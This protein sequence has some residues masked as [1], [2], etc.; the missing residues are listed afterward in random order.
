[1]SYGVGGIKE[2]ERDKEKTVSEEGVVETH[3]RNGAPPA[4]GQLVP[5]H[6]AAPGST[7]PAGPSEENGEHDASFPGHTGKGRAGEGAG[8]MGEVLPEDK[9]RS[10]VHH[11]QKKSMAP[12]G[13]EP[14]NRTLSPRRGQGSSEEHFLHCLPLN[15][16]AVAV[17]T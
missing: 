5:G 6:Q 13:A 10:M 1:M 9:V 4:E 17:T 14:S 12:L 11:V 8:R 16:P 2:E 3:S 15:S 7:S